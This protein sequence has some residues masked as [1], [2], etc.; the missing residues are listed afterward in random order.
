LQRL[1][2][3]RRSVVVDQASI[4]ILR[5][6]FPTK[7]LAE[8]GLARPPRAKDANREGWLQGEDR[9][10]YAAGDCGVS[11]IVRIVGLKR[12]VGNQ[13]RPRQ[14]ENG[15]RWAIRV[16]GMEPSNTGGLKSE[17]SGFPR[18]RL[19]AICRSSSLDTDAPRPRQNLQGHSSTPDR[20]R[21]N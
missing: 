21:L 4:G 18:T 7:Q 11:E 14:G 13:I 9:L 1:A 10:G 16:H 3:I 15:V 17:L 19:T 12:P 5:R 2:A 6:K 8:A 20:W